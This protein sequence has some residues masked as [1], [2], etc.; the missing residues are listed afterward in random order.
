M[1]VKTRI[2]RRIKK[3]KILEEFIGLFTDKPIYTF[4]FKDALIHLLV[5]KKFDFEFYH[6]IVTGFDNSPRSGKNGYILKGYTPEL[7]R[8]HLK[9]VLPK[10]ADSKQKII[11]I[12]SW[13]E[14]AEGNYLEPDMLF[15]N[16]FLKVLKDEIAKADI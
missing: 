15:G 4:N 3:T 10:V 1:F 14:W 16:Q 13:N 9:Q 7:F 11:F 5:D 12:K 8:L 6:T 2:K